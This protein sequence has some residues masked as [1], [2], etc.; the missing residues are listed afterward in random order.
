MNALGFV[1]E[2]NYGHIG[3]NSPYLKLTVYQILD[4]VKF[5]T[6]LATHYPVHPSPVDVPKDAR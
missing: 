3:C 5:V 4:L 1:Q 6:T 2:G